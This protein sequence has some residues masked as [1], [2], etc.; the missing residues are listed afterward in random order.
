[1]LQDLAAET[2]SLGLQGRLEETG[3]KDLE[4]NLVTKVPEVQMV[5]LALLV[6]MA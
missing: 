2:A 4:D 6:E 3:L 5:C 1:V